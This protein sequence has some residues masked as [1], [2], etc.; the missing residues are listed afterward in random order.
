MIQLTELKPGRDFIGVGIGVMIR[1]EKGEFLLGQRAK[2]SG[3]ELNKWC[4]PGGSV[5]F[6][7]TIF[8][9]AKRESLEEA[10]LVV[11]PMKL[12]KIIDHIIPAEKQHWV[13][14]IIEA[15]LVSGEPKILEP[16]KM[17]KWQWFSLENLPEN[18]T[19]NLIELFAGIKEGKIKLD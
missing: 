16:D 6:G 13:N 15:K 11:E 7:E 12:V 8:N 3:N 14:P 17:C 18:L 1:N 2:N 9:C 10:G 5:E 4:F 19:L